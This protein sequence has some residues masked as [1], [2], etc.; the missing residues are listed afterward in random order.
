MVSLPFTSVAS[1][2]AMRPPVTAGPMLRA[3]SPEKVSESTV[4][5]AEGDCA[6]SEM[7]SSS[8]GAYRGSGFMRVLISVAILWMSKG[9]GAPDRSAHHLFLRSVFRHIRLLIGAGRR[10]R[11]VRGGLSLFRCCRSRA[12]GGHLEDGI[13]DWR[14]QL[15]GIDGDL[16][17][18]RIALDARFH[19]HGEHQ[20][21]DVFVIAHAGFHFLVSTAHLALRRFPDGQ[22]T[23][24]VDVDIAYVTVL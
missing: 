18:L 3:F 21:L 13:F 11:L 7:V 15:D 2:A 14:I 6:A 20:A 4:V 12:G 24:R 10:S 19:G 5:G 1:M 16:L 8:A 9:K 23:V 17:G 22:V